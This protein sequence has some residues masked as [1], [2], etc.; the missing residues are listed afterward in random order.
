MLKRLPILIAVIVLAVW[1]GNFIV[2][3]FMA[4][5]L[6]AYGQDEVSRDLAIG[7]A[8]ANP[9]VVAARGKFLLYRAA[10]PQEEEAITELRRAAALSPYDFRFWL[11]LGRGYEAIGDSARAEPALRRA[12][13]LAPRYFETRWSV[14]N[15]LLRSG[16][17]DLALGEFREAVK[18]SGGN[19]TYPD[20]MA[21]LN[22]LNTI[23]GAIGRDFDALRSVTPQD[24]IS[25]IYLAEFFATHDALDQALEIQRR[26]GAGGT[27]DYR[28]LL[29][30]LLPILQRKGRFT[31]LREIWRD[32][33]R[34]EGGDIDNSTDSLILN[35]GFEKPAP[36]DKY[37]ALLSPPTGLNWTMR[38]HPE[39][40]ARR[41]NL[42]RH[43]GSYSLRLMFNSVMRSEFQDISQLV[44]VEPKQAYRLSYFVKTKQISAPAP[45]IE[46]TDAMNPATLSLKSEVP[47]GTNGWTEQ[48]ITFN[49][50]ETTRA[51][52]LTIRSPQ[53]SVVDRLL[54]GEVW[55]DDF[56]LE[57][58]N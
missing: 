26:G 36:S 48:S 49:A 31:E 14:A 44:I 10:P 24:R 4:V 8:P 27:G 58:V 1:V 20:R 7:Y 15:F 34:I 46:I 50:P 38:H 55:F 19:S 32:L 25:Q 22:A 11:E 37:P 41:D 42:E 45:F 52:R 2:K 43:S 12:V 54:I 16:Q 35:P 3:N 23:S 40:L 9:L 56:K 33:A 57:P 47:N 5:S 39:V 51:V 53:L 30:Q 21:T 13:E 6:I 29:F 28:R 18:A 17:T